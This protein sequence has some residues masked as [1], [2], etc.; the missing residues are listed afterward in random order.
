MK[1]GIVVIIVG[2]LFFSL[3]GFFL[4]QEMIYVQQYINIRVVRR[5]KKTF[6]MSGKRRNVY[7]HF[8]FLFFSYV[9]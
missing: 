1:C 5:L 6:L 8:K 3:T 4:N 2:Y 9:R 7:P